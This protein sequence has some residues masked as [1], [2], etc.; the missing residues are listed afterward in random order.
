MAATASIAA[1]SMRV[2]AFVFIV[3][4]CIYEVYCGLGRTYI[5][6]RVIGV[7]LLAAVGALKHI[8][9]GIYPADADFGLDVPALVENP[10]ITIGD[11]RSGHPTLESVL[12]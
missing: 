9:S 12:P 3:G 4:E 6:M 1:A 11:T 10:R 7:D 8:I 5:V 2:M